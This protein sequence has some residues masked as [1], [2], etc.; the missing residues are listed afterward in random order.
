M[1]GHD[2]SVHFLYL[3]SNYD[4]PWFTKMIN[5]LIRVKTNALMDQTSVMLMQL[6][7]ILREHM[8]VIA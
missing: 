4:G 7:K 6:V 1:D 3:F 8:T 5:A 2:P